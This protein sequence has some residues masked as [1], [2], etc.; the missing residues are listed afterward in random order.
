M[1]TLSDETKR[2]YGDPYDFTHPVVNGVREHIR[3]VWGFAGYY[4]RAIDAALRHD[5]PEGF[6]ELMRAAEL[7]ADTRTFDGMS[8]AQ[9]CDKR[10]AARC[11]K[12]IKT[13][14]DQAAIRKMSA[15]LKG[16][17]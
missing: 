15:K 7:D 11:K 6:V 17:A 13:L 8:M 16:A 3:S 5:D 1:S 14:Q 2:K 10:G 4:E 12:A 9:Y